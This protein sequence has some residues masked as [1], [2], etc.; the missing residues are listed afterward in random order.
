M[1]NLFFI[2]FFLFISSACSDNDEEPI[3]PDTVEIEDGDWNL[4]VE[5]GEILDEKGK[6][7]IPYGFNSVHIWLDESLSINALRYEIPKSGAN[8]V[9]IV[10]A[11]SSWTWN[12]QSNTA[13][14]RRVLVK[15]AIDG[16]LIPMLELHDGT[17]LSDCS[18]EASDGKMGLEQIVDEWLQPENV[19]LLKD[20]EGKLMMN[21]ANEWGPQNDDYLVCYK[22]AITRI[23][24]AGIKNIIV[25]DAGNCGQGAN[26]LL[27]YGD[28]LFEH[29]PLKNIVLSIHLY[30]FWRTSDKDFT[31]WT[32][33]FS[34]ETDIPKLAG[35]K[36]PV[37][38]GEFGWS[39]DESAINYDPLKT[40]KILKE[41]NIGWLF[42][43]WYD[44]SSTEYYNSV[45][46]SEYRFNDEEDL[47]PA[48]HIIINDSEL[49]MKKNA[50]KPSGMKL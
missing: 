31:N 5:N 17:C 16:K 40:L 45:L 9:R 1:R 27:N 11:G 14:K 38:V 33:P 29:D 10:S 26:T 35:L 42:W 37:I 46:N 25:I 39:G 3:T 12:N 34:V 22:N 13:A 19:K 43:S 2:V 20:Y 6:V 49:G 18:L 32:P 4:H 15:N 30:G 8:T 48:G 24:N 7:F 21:V 50:S 23:R 36:A 28:E 41:N 44:D 47:S